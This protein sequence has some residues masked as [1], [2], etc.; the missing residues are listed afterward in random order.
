[1]NLF[2]GMENFISDTEIN[3]KH[4]MVCRMCFCIALGW[5]VGLVGGISVFFVMASIGSAL[6]AGHF[7]RAPK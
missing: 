3:I 6:T 1:V 2:D 4:K 5:V 7:G